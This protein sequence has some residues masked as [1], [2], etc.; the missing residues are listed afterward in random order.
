ML[1][2]AA[3]S[4]FKIN[5]ETRLQYFQY[6]WVQGYKESSSNGRRLFAMEQPNLNSEVIPSKTVGYIE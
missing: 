6:L 2:D 4:L 3:T 5:V 1:V